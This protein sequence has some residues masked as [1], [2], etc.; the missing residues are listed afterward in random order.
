MAGSEEESSD[1]HWS[2][3]FQR[4]RAETVVLSVILLTATQ[5]D[6]NLSKLPILGVEFAKPAPKG[7][8]LAF[9]Y[10]F[11]AYFC[12]AWVVRYFAERGAIVFPRKKISAFLSNLDS[13]LEQA[14]ALA[15]PVARDLFQNLKEFE[16]AAAEVRSEYNE[17]MLPQIRWY[18]DNY[19]RYGEFVHAFTKAEERGYLGANS[20]SLPN[21]AIGE[22]RTHFNEIV[23]KMSIL[24][25][26]LGE[27][28]NEVKLAQRMTTEEINAKGPKFTDM[29]SKFNDDMKQLKK[30]L[31]GLRSNMFFD[32]EIFGFFIPF[33]FSIC[34]VFYSAFQG[35]V[36]AKPALLRFTDCFPPSWECVLRSPKLL[37]AE[38]LRLELPAELRN[39]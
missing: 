35:W 7:A 22:P 17:H 29:I 1:K 6:L 36:D 11:F 24:E 21:F 34:L 13:S 28:V 12:C 5:L 15:F 16:R 26:V 23:E 39:L 27:A 18:S 33:L 19:R 3:T 37:D 2:S 38:T 10:L 4:L 9:I 31:R 30:Q 8:L 20:I 32:M 14:N 25:G